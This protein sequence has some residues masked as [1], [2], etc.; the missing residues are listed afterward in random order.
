MKQYRVTYTVDTSTEPDCVLDANDPVHKLLKDSFMGG[1]PG[2]NAYQVF[3]EETQDRPQNPY[4][5][6]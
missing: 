5:Q 2:I 6:H 1:V 3:P 4:G